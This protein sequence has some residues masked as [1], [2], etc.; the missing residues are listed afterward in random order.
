[1]NPQS[2]PTTPHNS[3]SLLNILIGLAIRKHSERC[4]YAMDSRLRCTCGAD[5]HNAK[6]QGSAIGLRKAVYDEIAAGVKPATT[7]VTEIPITET[8][9]EEPPDEKQQEVKPQMSAPK[10]AP[11]FTTGTD[12][13]GI[14]GNIPFATQ[15]PH[16]PEDVNAG[17]PA[18]PEAAKGAVP[19]KKKA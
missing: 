3:E 11:K 5:L 15:Q 6:V 16:N 7:P 1:M 4:E 18:A 13:P 10:A 12:I 19:P 17:K 2:Q 14:E 9:M 8:R